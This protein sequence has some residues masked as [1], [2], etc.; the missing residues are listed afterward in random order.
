MVGETDSDLR[1][2]DSLKLMGA[3]SAVVPLVGQNSNE[4]SRPRWPK[5]S[6]VPLAIGGRSHG[7]RGCR[8]ETS[9]S[10]TSPDH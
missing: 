3:Q 4:Y 1:F 8:I 7:D 9:A 5:T 10:G 2:D 6:P